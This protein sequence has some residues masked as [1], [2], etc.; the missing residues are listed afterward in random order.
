M[1]N[2][3][4]KIEYKGTHYCGWQIQPNVITIE[5]TIRKAIRQICQYPVRIRCCGRTD[6]GVHAKGQVADVEVPDHVDPNRLLCSLNSLLPNDISIVQLVRVPTGFSARRENCGK[7]YTFSILTSPMPR[8]FEF[9]TCLWRRDVLDLDRLKPAM[10]D[11]VG[12]HD[13]SAFR[14]KGCQQPSPVKTMQ[15]VDIRLEKNEVSTR[16]DLVFEGSGFLKN[17]VRI[18]AGTLLEIASGKYG[19]DQIRK[20]LNSGRREDAGIT[21]PAKGLVLEKV[22]FNNDPFMNN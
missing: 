4:L 9:D 17:M 20:A 19:T 2:L 15:S 10:Q 14:G 8:V 22:F 1:L 13:F 5:E 18:M 7:R 6:A 16:T 3:L 12:T 11:L 21:A